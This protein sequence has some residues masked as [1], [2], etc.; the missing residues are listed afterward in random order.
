[1]QQWGGLKPGSKGKRALA[2]REVTGVERWNRSSWRLASAVLLSAAFA[3]TPMSALAQEVDNPGPATLTLL[4]GSFLQVGDDRFD[5]QT[6]GSLS[7]SIDADGVLSIPADGVNIPEFSV[8]SPL[9]TVFVKIV[10]LRDAAGFL[11]P[12]SGLAAIAGSLSINLRGGG[13]PSGCRIEPV[14][15]ELTTGESGSLTGTAYSQDDGTLTLVDGLFTIPAAT[16]ENCGFASF[17]IN[18]QFGL[19]SASGRNRILLAGQSD[20]I[21][22]APS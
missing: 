8:Q 18:S 16:F 7:G 19:P 22:V 15:L 12:G 3:L 20:P 10:A 4:P 14:D 13:V 21:F 1:M 9:G 11:S 6:G 17:F 5:F 2:L